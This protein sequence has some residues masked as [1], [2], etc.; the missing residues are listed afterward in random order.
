MYGSRSEST[1]RVGEVFERRS[2]KCALCPRHIPT[3][4]NAYAVFGSVQ[5]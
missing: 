4:R 1:W 3:V 5:P 2:D